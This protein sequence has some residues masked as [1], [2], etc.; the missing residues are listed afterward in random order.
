M[1]A[2]KRKAYLQS[3]Q[4]GYPMLIVSVDI[5]GPLPITDEGNKYVLVVMDYF[6]RWAEAYPTK[7][8]EATTVARKLVDEMFCRFSPLEQLHSDQGRQFE[9]ELIERNLFN[10]TLLDMLATTAHNHPSDLYIRK[11][12]LAYNSSSHSTIGFSPFFLMFGHE[13]KLPVDLMYGSN[14]QEQTT[15]I[16]YVQKLKDGLRDAYSQ[17][18]ELCEAEHK[19]Q[20]SLYDEKVHVNK[21]GLPSR[22]RGDKG[23]ENTSVARFMLQHP[24]RCINR[25]SFIGGHSVHNQHIERLWRNLYVGVLDLYKQLFMY[26]ESVHLLNPCNELDLFALHYVYTER[27]NNHIAEWTDAW[28]RDRISSEGK[29]SPVQLWT[30]GMIKRIG[31]GSTIAQELEADNFEHISQNAVES[32]GID[33]EE[34]PDE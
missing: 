30:M 31:S 25:G 7:N 6:P 33:W 5:M 3:I 16:E 27:I 24:K 26:L 9:S 2:P 29:K 1:P 22:V 34:L 8:Q 18:H 10:R 13:V 12:C 15:A 19:R 23:G 17:V 21:H 20:K 4:V 32:F 11:V 28:N 14:P